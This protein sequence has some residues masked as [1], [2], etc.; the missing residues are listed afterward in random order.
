MDHLVNAIVAHEL[1]ETADYRQRFRFEKSITRIKPSQKKLLQSQ[2]SQIE[3]ARFEKIIGPSVL[4]SNASDK[5]LINFKNDGY[6]YP[7]QLKDEY[8]QKVYAALDTLPFTNRVTGDVLYSSDFLE[9]S[10]DGGKLSDFKGTYWLSDGT[11]ENQ[12]FLLSETMQQ[13]AFDPGILNLVAE[14][15]QATPIHV[16]TNAW[17]S[18]SS[19]SQNEVSVNA[20]EFHQDCGFAQ[21][22]KVFIYLSDTSL[23]NGPHSFVRGSCN[24]DHHE[25]IPGYTESKRISKDTLL[26]YYP[27]ECFETICGNRGTVILGDTS[28]FHRGEPVIEG[29]RLMLNLEY[30]SSLF[31]SS[32]NYFHGSPK[33]KYLDNVCEV[34]KLRITKNYRPE[35]AQTYDEYYSKLNVLKRSARRKILTILGRE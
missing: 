2:I 12:K 16:A 14:Y 7:L 19:T 21:F 25:L 29:A 26:E 5:Q 22:V 3:G 28:C 8:I 33:V 18:G 24:G 30:T 15:L 11:P 34:N 13:I 1:N 6:L 4:S 20:Q 23:K 31:G 10:G 17:F 35:L 32:V 27:K 9:R